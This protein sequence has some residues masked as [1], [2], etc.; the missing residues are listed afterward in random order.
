MAQASDETRV[1]FLR[2]L[3]ESDL[4]VLTPIMREA[5]DEDSAIHLNGAKGGPPGYDNGDFLRKWFLHPK[6]TPYVIMLGDRPIGAVNLW[7]HSDGNNFLGCLF[8]DPAYE[9]Q[10]YGLRVWHM[11]EALYPKTVSWKTETPIF[12]HRNHNF[13]I[14][15]CH[16]KC[17][18]IDNPKD[19]SEGS[20]VLE[21]TMK[22]G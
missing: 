6:A 1:L 12:S 17:V 15:K 16:F 8:L 21:K 3:T 2:K 19:L 5:F 18:R 13:Y 14:N 10:G 4:P 9:N 20:F 11:V 22:E 7:I